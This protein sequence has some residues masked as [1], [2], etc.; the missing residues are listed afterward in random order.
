MNKFKGWFGIYTL[1]QVINKILFTYQ[2][3]RKIIFEILYISFASKIYHKISSRIIIYI[4]NI[5]GFEKYNNSIILRSLFFSGTRGMS[6]D[7]IMNIREKHFE[8]IIL[9]DNKIYNK[10]FRDIIFEIR[11]RGYSDISNLFNLKEDEINKVITYFKTQELYNGHDPLQSDLNKIKYKNI[12]KNNTNHQLFNKGYFSYDAGTSLKN[13]QI[14]KLVNSKR[15]KLLADL[16]CGFDTELYTISTL[17]NTKEKFE[18]PVANFHRDTDDLITFG[19]F[20]YWTKTTQ[21]NGATKYILGS[22]RKV[23]TNNNE[24]ILDANPGTIIAG[25]WMGL[26]SGNNNMEEAERL[27]TILRFGKKINNCYMQTKSFYFF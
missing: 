20:I 2:K 17:L 1:K 23:T 16:Y 12:Y 26:H 14:N 4:I 11:D 13:D 19:F 15:L 10:D 22:H 6:I 21:N 3:K 7:E 25:D 9:N 27:I 24:Q 8:K 18:H 5:F